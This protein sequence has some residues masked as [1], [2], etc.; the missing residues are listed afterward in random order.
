[1]FVPFEALIAKTD[2]R[3]KVLKIFQETLRTTVGI[4][5]DAKDPV[6][7]RKELIARLRKIMSAVGEARR[8]FRWFKEVSPVLALREGSAARKEAV[9]HRWALAVGSKAALFIHLMCDR[10]VWLIKHAGFSGSAPDTDRRSKTF[11]TIA[12]SCNLAMGMLKALEAQAASKGAAAVR[13]HLMDTLKHLLSF[14]Q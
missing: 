5:A 10:H 6:A 3:D 13:K 11:A 8:T 1:M 2:G 14:L 4:L 9:M 12:H 7:A